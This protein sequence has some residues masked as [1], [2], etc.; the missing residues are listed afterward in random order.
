MIELRNVSKFYSD[1]NTVTTGLKNVTLKLRRGEFVAIVGD[2]GS[3]KSTLLNVITSVDTYD[4]GEILFLGNETFQ[5][6]QDDSDEFKK[7]NVSFVFQK[8]N[9]IDSYTVLQNVALPLIIK[10]KSEKEAEAEALKIIERVGLSERVS[11]RG[12]NLSGGEKQRLSIARAIN[13]AS[14]V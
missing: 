3:G 11:N 7:N 5:F 12:S 14:A 2:S 6:T 8:Y 10:G 4:E 13:S 1:G 9:I